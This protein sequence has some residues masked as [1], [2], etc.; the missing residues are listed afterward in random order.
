MGRTEVFDFPM[1]NADHDPLRH[2]A[3]R[4][5]LAQRAGAGPEPCAVAEAT[6]GLWGQMMHRLEPVIGHRGVEVLF[7]RAL[8]LTSGAFP[9]LDAGDLDEAAADPPVRLRARLEALEAAP[10]LEAGAALLITL[11]D[12]LAFLVGASLTERLLGPVW[13]ALPPAA[14]EG[15]PP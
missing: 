9:W 5:A 1:P 2:Q 14:G 12:L 15:N 6:L 11:T 3:I 4:Q 8:N 10:C 7:R 13:E